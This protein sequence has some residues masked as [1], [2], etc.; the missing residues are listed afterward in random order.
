MALM[1]PVS[2]YD[3]EEWDAEA[4]WLAERGK[5]VAEAVSRAVRSAQTPAPVSGERRRGKGERGENTAMV[6]P[7]GGASELTVAG[8][9]YIGSLYNRPIGEQDCGS[10]PE[11]SEGDEGEREGVRSTQPA[12]MWA[13][14]NVHD[15]LVC[16]RVRTV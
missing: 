15:D 12:G 6:Y 14:R 2:G 3:E 4:A 1:A 5:D 7:Q 9:L 10:D 8:I 16:S 13:C 11:L